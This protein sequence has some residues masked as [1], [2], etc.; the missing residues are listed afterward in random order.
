[1][2]KLVPVLL[3]VLLF[4]GCTLFNMGNTPTKKTEV[5]L[6]KY[7][8]L[9]KTIMTQLDDVVN[10]DDTLTTTQ[11]DEYKKIIKNQYQ[12]MIYSIKDEVIDG[13]S[14]TVKTEV[15]VYDLDDALDRANDYLNTNAKEFDDADGKF[16]QTKFNDYKLKLMNE[17]KTKIKY[18]LDL[19]LAKNNAT[20]IMND[21]TETERQKIHGI[22]NYD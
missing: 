22:Y 13:D 12:N 17:Q 14:A 2:K 15:E 8:M 4:S 20:W 6:K 11:K 18:T 16:S 1:M 7:Q 21:L 19:T 9:D 5:L 10:G 3:V